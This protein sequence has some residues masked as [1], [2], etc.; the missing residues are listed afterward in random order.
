MM[1]P[2][3]RHQPHSNKI[4]KR[5]A[6]LNAVGLVLF[7][8]PGAVAFA[9]DFY[10]GAI[11]LPLEHTHPEYGGNLKQPPSDH[12]AQPISIP[13]AATKSQDQTTWQQ[14]GF[15]RIMIPKDQLAS[16]QIEKQV[17]LHISKPISIAQGQFR[18]STLEQL[19][20][21][22]EQANLH[23]ADPNFGSVA[24]SFTRSGV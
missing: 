5:I 11:F 2:E 17:N 8:V 24:S 16:E 3:R 19:D 9:V 12:S 4:D 6:G 1:H 15:K 13:T 14:L 18:M 20:Q 10:T 22:A 21:F 7:F 23:R